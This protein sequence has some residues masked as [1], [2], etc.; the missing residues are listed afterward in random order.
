VIRWVVILCMLQAVAFWKILPRMGFP[1]WLAI[2]ASVPLLNLVLFYY[3]AISPWPNDPRI[4]PPG[5]DGSGA[6][7]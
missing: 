1:P 3:L 2:L 4:L 6:K 5:P 7:P